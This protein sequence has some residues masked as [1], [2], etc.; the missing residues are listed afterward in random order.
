MRLLL[1][2]HGE[3]DWTREG[4]FTGWRD[5]PLNA[6]GRRQAEAA[7]AA[8][9]GVAPAA[10]YAS[11]LARA[12]ATAEIVAAPHG[13][14]VRLE[15]A[16]RE[17]GF[18]AWEGLT[19]AEVAARDPE[20]FDAWRTAPGRFTAP[21]GEAVTAVAA[22]VGQGLARLRAA[23]AGATVILVTHGVVLRLLVLDALGLGLDR[24]WAVDA[25][26]AGLTEF[27]YRDGWVTVHRVNA[28]AHLAAAGAEAGP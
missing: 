16:F 3:T 24:L 18:G 8:L 23:H 15:P 4:R 17:M 1:L 26:P 22:R 25:A 20:G 13:L 14:A 2:R 6:A 9:A 12:R 21:G 28:V 27:E 7:A 11:P 19:R 5:V 10:V